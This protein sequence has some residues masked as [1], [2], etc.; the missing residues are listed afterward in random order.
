MG[1]VRAYLDFTKALVTEFLFLFSSCASGSSGFPQI[2]NQRH[3][4]RVICSLFS[5]MISASVSFKD[6][7]PRRTAQLY[8]PISLRFAWVSGVDRAHE[9]RGIAAGVGRAQGLLDVMSER[10]LE[11]HDRLE[12]R[13]EERVGRVEPEGVWGFRCSHEVNEV[14]SDQTV[15]SQASHVPSHSFPTGYVV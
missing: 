15:S 8:S 4:I 14:P 11:R 6:Y 5:G 1:A 10:R 12:G 7:K 2:H 3:T 9:R 13:M